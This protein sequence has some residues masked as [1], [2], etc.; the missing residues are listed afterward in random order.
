M[1]LH[2]KGLKLKHS[3][4]YLIRNKLTSAHEK[5]RQ[6]A[7]KAGAENLPALEGFQNKNPIEKFLALVTDGQNQMDEATKMVQEMGEK[8]DQ[9][10]PGDML[11]IQIKLQKAAQELEFT[12]MMLGRAIDMIKTLFN[13]QI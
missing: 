5:L 1:Q 4:K 2:T 11:Y 12:S 8:G 3:D 9:L 13:V 7:E 6:A 10:N